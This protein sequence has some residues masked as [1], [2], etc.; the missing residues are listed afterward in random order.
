M[1]EDEMVGG[2][3]QLNG[4]KFAQTP[5]Y[6]E[7]QGSLARYSPW[8]QR[9]IH[10]LMTKQQQPHLQR[11][12]YTCEQTQKHLSLNYFNFLMTSEVEYTERLTSCELYYYVCFTLTLGLMPM[13]IEELS[14]L[15]FVKLF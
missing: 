15:Y 14:L 8:G 1:T 11:L 3:H 10:N 7:G 12:S 4:H 6:S 13:K 9:V 5:G 2:H